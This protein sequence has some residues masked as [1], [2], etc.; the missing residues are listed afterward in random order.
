MT[1]EKRTTVCEC[2]ILALIAIYSF[3]MGMG[4]ERFLVQRAAVH[5]R[6]AHYEV[7]EWGQT[8]FIWGKKEE[9]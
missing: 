3:L 9:W 8:T 6:A 2:I 5:N 1:P 4:V 7:N